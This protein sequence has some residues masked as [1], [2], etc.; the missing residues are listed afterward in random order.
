M[1]RRQKNARRQK[2]REW[3]GVVL[4][5]SKYECWPKI[6]YVSQSKAER[7]IEDLRRDGKTR[8]T[9]D[10]ILHAYCCNHCDSWH[11]GH[12]KIVILPEGEET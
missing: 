6:G 1:H 3:H 4:F 2:H 11:I 5:N 8:E 12:T 10:Y 9:E 7:A